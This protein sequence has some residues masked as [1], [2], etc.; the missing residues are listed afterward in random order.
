LFANLFGHS[1]IQ[2]GGLGEKNNVISSFLFNILEKKD[3][4]L[5]ILIFESSVHCGSHLPHVAIEILV[6]DN[7]EFF[8]VEYCGF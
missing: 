8:F 5:K 6:C 2:T 3:N 7:I 4:N 1:F